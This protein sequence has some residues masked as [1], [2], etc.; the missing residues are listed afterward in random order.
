MLHFI[1]VVPPDWTFRFMGSPASVAHLNSSVAVRA[2]VAAGKLALT[3]IPPNMTTGSQ[4]EI[5]R[6]LTDLWLW[7][8]VLAPAEHV[9]VFQTDSILCANSRRTLN[10]FLDYD[11]VGAPWAADSRFGGNGGL[12]LRRRSA[13]VD[14]LRHQVRRNNSEAEDVWI[15]DRL[16]HRPGARLADGHVSAVF[17]GESVQGE[18]V[19][20]DGHQAANT[21]MTVGML[22]NA[23]A[24]AGG[25]HRT[26]TALPDAGKKVE[27]L[28]AWRD[29][30]Y[31]PMGYHTGG[32]G[33]LLP[34]GLWGT[35]EKRQ[36]IWDYCPEIKMTLSMEPAQYIPLSCNGFWKRDGE[37]GEQMDVE[38]R[39]YATETIDG[40]EYPALSGMMPWL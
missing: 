25:L 1:S 35:P 26:A 30:F 5:S 8:T 36:H 17:S 39:G 24:A 10:D 27:G 2:H 21:S 4:E 6:F 22:R 37:E 28:D 3:Y 15:T 18:D 9:L 14:V 33:T 40:V 12:S 31:E 13:V 11:Y 23:T 20:L 16:G 34:S 29:G 32:S 38:P 19:A 7:E